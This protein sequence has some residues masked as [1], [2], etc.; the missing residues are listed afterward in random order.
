MRK[1]LNKFLAVFVSFVMAIT[2][3]PL[4]GIVSHAENDGVEVGDSSSVTSVYE[5]VYNPTTLKTGDEVII[6][7]DTNAL[8]A[9]KDGNIGKDTIKVN[10][11]IVSSAPEGTV[12]KVSES[13]GS[14]TFANDNVSGSNNKLNLSRNNMNIKVSIGEGNTLT[15]SSKG[16]IYRSSDTSS[17][18][19]YYLIYK[20]DEF[21]GSFTG[22]IANVNGLTFYK[23]VNRAQL[24]INYKYDDQTKTVTKDVALGETVDVTND[25]PEKEEQ[26]Y[27]FEKMVYNS[28]DYNVTNVKVKG[29]AVIDVYYQTAS[30]TVKFN[31]NF[32][33]NGIKQSDSYTKSVKKG[34][35]NVSIPS[36]YSQY[37]FSKMIVN[38]GNEQTTIT[39][40]F[41]VNSDTTVKYYYL[42]PGGPDSYLPDGDLN[43]PDEPDYP[44][45]GAVRLNKTADSSIFSATGLTRVEL[46]VTGVPVKKG[47]DVVIVLD[48][49]GS[50]AWDVNGEKTR[51]QSE[52]RIYI[53]KEAA[54]NFARK[55]LA[56]NEDGTKSN[57]RV[58]V[59]SFNTY[60]NKRCDLKNSD[61][62][63]SVI[64]AINA[65]GGSNNNPSGGTNYDAGVEQAKNILES[66]KNADGYNRSQA[67]LFMSDGAPTNGYNGTYDFNNNISYSEFGNAMKAHTYSTDVKNLGATMYTVGF[68]LADSNYFTKAQCETVLR[69][70]MASGTECFKS[71][72][73]ASELNDTF[74]NIAAAIKKAGTEAT[75]TDTIGPAFELQM[76]APSQASEF[77]T[78]IKVSSYD[79]D[80]KGNKTGNPETIEV[81]TFSK[82]GKT[83]KSS[84]KGDTN[85]LDAD[86]NI[87]AEKFTYDAKTRTFSWRIGDITQKEIVLS[88][89]EYLTDSMSSTGVPR[90]NYPTNKGDA[91]LK[92]TNY[93]GNS[94]TKTKESPELPWGS[95]S[96]TVEYY[97]VNE[98][99]QPVN[100]D[101]TVIKEGFKKV[102][103]EKTV[104]ININ[105]DTT[106]KANDPNYLP[107]GYELLNKDAYY[108]VNHPGQTNAEQ[109]SSHNDVQD[110]GSTL[111][112]G[113]KPYTTSTV[114]FGV[115]AK[116]DLKE[117]TVVLDYGKPVTIDVRA[118]DGFKSATLNG[119][120]KTFDSTKVA[121]N[122]GV[123]N[124]SIGGFINSIDGSYGTLEVKD[125]TKGTVKY[126]P[127]KYMDGIDKY[128]YEV[129]GSVDV[130]DNDK[131]TKKVDAYK[132][133]SV[134]IIPAT[135]VYYEDNFSS[136]TTNEDGTTNGI[137][138]G[139]IASWTE[140]P[141][142]VTTTGKEEQDSEQGKDTT[143]G[144]D[145]SYANDTTFS[146]GSAH[147][148]TAEKG[149]PAMAK[150]TFK[151]TGFEIISRTDNNTGVM[152]VKVYDSNN[153]VV[154]N[155]PCDT[156]Y[157]Q[158]DGILYQ[159]PVISVDGLPYGQYKVIITVTSTTDQNGDSHNSTVY[160]DG[161]RIFNPIDPNGTDDEAT[162]ANNKYKED[163]EANQV[164]YE[165]RNLLLDND[166]LTGDTD[167]NGVV[168]VD[169][170]GNIEDTTTYKDL[171]PN[172]EVYLEKGNSIGFKL[173]SSQPAA[174]KIGLKTPDGKAGKVTVGSSK[175]SSGDPIVL[176]TATSMYY[177]V[178]NKIVFNDKNEAYV[179]ITNT[180][181]NDAIVSLTKIKFTF[182]S[183][184]AISP[185]LVVN[186]NDAKYITNLA[187]SRNGVEVDDNNKD[188]TSDD[189]PNS[190]TTDKPNS[191]TTDKP[192]NNTSVINKV[193]NF[194]KNLFKK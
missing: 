96:I 78:S 50:M 59:V 111:V 21:S 63:E 180:G 73:T 23:K 143:Y 66:A 53:A 90:G 187:L 119:V 105:Q 190:D 74:Q 179:V 183:K 93:K 114:S 70:W 134:S 129:K 36:K 86:G 83:A 154:K 110:K 18:Y 27:N 44:K 92:Y 181:D 97:L 163:N 149:K 107:S 45:Q 177:D 104:S 82:D 182:E 130:I 106:I 33:V 136:G 123:K 29:N 25:F 153:K 131:T 39:T 188:N 158:K 22:N 172:N 121:L 32:Y 20:N 24:T 81:V 31:V 178:T 19:Y 8:K 138:Y 30:D 168:Y 1:I 69:D 26:S 109:L 34:T 94:I 57:N 147:V 55:I 193:V 98:N 175:D 102:I 140:T 65:I 91:S 13:N 127:T 170:K 89:A 61:N 71:V 133:S 5:K 15:I 76:A 52:R 125:N 146:Y 101:G 47:I 12:W 148:V 60:S 95:A 139:G 173:K 184:P 41:D 79:L 118:N 87:D 43:G 6:A 155:I 37:N 67:V 176:N 100:Y 28:T 194:F 169:S 160:I 35:K 117:D 88:F 51:T 185:Q 113:L 68:G 42:N 85:I 14:Y 11:D 126:T 62:L 171:G 2:M 152:N 137:V 192:N 164:V 46:G 72:K 17:K 84:L 159:I 144:Q 54:R 99:G 128:Y 56:A 162:E 38:D 49:S 115:L 3:I 112:S 145:S 9:D 150:F 157:Q 151:G 108:T 75:L 167:A 141:E 48:E 120:S 122:T 189:K 116:S 186:Q 174:I 64:S 103:D 165:I 16:Q 191:D 10:D 7:Y 124:E 166:S 142:N 40:K 135:S 132:Y 4:S 58:S 161:I 77:D 156:V 80:E